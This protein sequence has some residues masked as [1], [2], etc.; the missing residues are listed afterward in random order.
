MLSASLRREKH[1][2]AV[3]DQLF[4]HAPEV[5]AALRVEA[6]GGLI[7]EEDVRSVYERGGEVEPTPHATA[8]RAGRSGGRVGEIE[9]REQLVGPRPDGLGLQVRQL[10]HHP[11]VL[12]AS[13]VLVDRGV[14]TGE[15]DALAHFLR[16]LAHI[17]TEHLG[18]PAAA[19]QNRG[20]DAYGCGLAGAVRSEETEHAAGGDREVDSVERDNGSELLFEVLDSDRMFHGFRVSHRY[21][22]NVKYL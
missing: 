18:P 21:L 8:V 16:V 4:D 22:N 17:N 19:G 2:R 15:A 12:V 6:G 3:G 20:E 11:E 9:T 7:E 5:R 13:E 1:R 10:S 14:L